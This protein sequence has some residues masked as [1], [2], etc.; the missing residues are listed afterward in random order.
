MIVKVC[1]KIRGDFV[2]I[3]V[4]VNGCF[5]YPEYISNESSGLFLLNHH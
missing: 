1:V 4:S 2:L 5:I 3:I